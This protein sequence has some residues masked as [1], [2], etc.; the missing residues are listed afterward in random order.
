METRRIIIS[1]LLYALKISVMSVIAALPCWFLRPVLL[2]A[3]EGHGRL[4]SA[5]VP[6]GLLALIFAVIGV[7]ELIITK[8]E[9]VMSIMKRSTGRA[10]G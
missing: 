9:I 1:N 10:R 3:F 4:V 5:G 6:A 7:L 2:N 8:D